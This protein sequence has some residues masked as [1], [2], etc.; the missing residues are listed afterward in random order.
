MT[1][2]FNGLNTQQLAS[3]KSILPT[4][5]NRHKEILSAINSLGGLATLGDVGTILGRQLNQISGRFTELNAKRM[6]T[7]SGFVKTSDQTKRAMTVWKLTE[8]GR[9]Y[10]NGN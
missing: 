1:E 10:L 4:L 7:D 2:E 5:S 3:Y 8:A 6:I 9:E